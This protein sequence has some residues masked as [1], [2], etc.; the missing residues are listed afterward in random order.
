MDDALR[1]RWRFDAHAHLP[2]DR[3]RRTR[4]LAFQE[5]IEHAMYLRRLPKT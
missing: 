1:G 3:R 5:A 4:V 2:E